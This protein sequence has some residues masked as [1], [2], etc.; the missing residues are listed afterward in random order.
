MNILDVCVI[1]FLGIGAVI[2]F[3]K[4]FIK[5]SV[6]FFGT[7]L[8]I[9]LAYYLKNPIS[10][11]L[12]KFMPFFTLAGIFKGVTVFNILI[13]EA[14]SFLLV[15]LILSIILSII[16]KI[17][18]IVEKIM[19]FTI[20]LGIPSKILGLIFGFFQ[21]FIYTF[22]ILFIL[23]QF[24]VTREF[25][26]ESNMAKT[27]LTKTPILSNIVSNA[28]NSVEEIVNIAKVNK[29]KN[30]VNRESLG[31]LL[32]YK[33]ISVEN[34]EYLISKKKIKISNFQEI[35]NRFKEV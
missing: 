18:G 13:Y 35:L 4:G 14:I 32:K 10:I 20:I 26:E 19:N 15:M 27:I 12:Y 34:A 23:A 6:T 25:I 5:S 3:K 17:T 8:I 11:F 9:I 29:D 22:L 7:L 33:L 31:I 1:L 21:F 2:G 28:Y 16:I 24:N 30:N